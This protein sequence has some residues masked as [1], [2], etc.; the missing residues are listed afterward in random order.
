M[1][2]DFDK[3]NPP[4]GLTFIYSGDLATLEPRFTNPSLLS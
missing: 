3:K 2:H 4:L 1:E